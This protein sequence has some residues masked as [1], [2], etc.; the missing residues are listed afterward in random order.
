MMTEPEE[1]ML[2]PP[3][4]YVSGDTLSVDVAEQ[5]ASEVGLSLSFSLPPEG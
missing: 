4:S 1:P 3:K 5:N 2:S